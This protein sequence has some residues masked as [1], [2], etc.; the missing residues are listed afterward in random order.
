MFVLDERGQ[1]DPGV[2]HGL[3]FSLCVFMCVCVCVSIVPCRY[4]QVSGVVVWLAKKLSGIE[5]LEVIE[6]WGQR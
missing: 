3:V 5:I 2:L 1:E 4:G 6:H